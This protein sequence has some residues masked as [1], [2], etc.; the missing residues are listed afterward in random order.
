M[1]ARPV[2]IKSTPSDIAGMFRAAIDH[3]D[4]IRAQSA[5]SQIPSSMMTDDDRAA[6]VD[7]MTA[8]IARLHSFP[9]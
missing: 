5:L 8:A 9:A 7:A 1:T 6:I 2:H 3:A 4:Y